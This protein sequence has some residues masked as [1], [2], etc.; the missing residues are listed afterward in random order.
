[1]PVK[2]P[3]LVTILV[4]LAWLLF[5]TLTIRVFGPDS[6]YVVFD[7]DGAIP[8]LMANE[9]RPITIF[10]TYYWGVD[11]WGGWPLMIARK[12]HQDTGF[13]WTDKRL[14]IVRA[15]WLFCGLLVLVFL[16]RRA[17]LAVLVSSLIPLCLEPTIRW[18][19]FNLSQVYAWQLTGLL[20]AWFGLRR[21]LA[22]EFVS[23]TGKQV[24]VRGTLWCLCFYFSA[25]FAIWSSEV[26]VPLLGFLLLLEGLRSYF[27][28]VSDAANKWKRARYVMSLL[29]L[30]AASLSAL[31]LK[32]NYHRHGRKHWGGDYKAPTWFD[33]G[34]LSQNLLANWRNLAEFDF[35]P[36]LIISCAFF[37]GITLVLAY[38]RSRGKRVFRERL[39]HFALDDTVTMV[40]AL[41]SMALI[42][43]AM[44]ICLSH[45]RLSSYNDRYLNP[46]FFFGSIAGL[47]TVYL[48]LRLLA[49]RIGVTRYAIPV[50]ILGAFVLL[51]AEFPRAK[52]SERYR[53][54]KETAL[55]LAQK[56]PGGFVM[57]G[58]WETYIFAAL[59][60]P[61]NRMTPLPLE[62]LQVRIPW[63]PAMLRDAKDVVIECR[64]NEVMNRSAL[65]AELTQYGNILK[66]KDPQFYQNSRYSFALYTNEHK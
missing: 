23:A 64:L 47:M 43:L 10:D 11:R 20:L 38:A 17:A 32:I 2:K 13:Q 52:P 31:L 53:L 60:Q 16:N 7:S 50:A 27:L 25:F 15:T 19:L 18:Q 49:D 6:E 42:N 62:G 57:G 66:L 34:Y 39:R 65:P 24:L 30:A 40:T 56:A 22:A 21:L 8:I 33:A 54:D 4:L 14:H 37:F 29:L 44:M 28:S 59:Q 35:L 55:I 63:T 48:M 41:S 58:Y 36:L 26:S 12:F 46:T 5:L 3:A 1:M 61:A 51:I 9:D 45:V